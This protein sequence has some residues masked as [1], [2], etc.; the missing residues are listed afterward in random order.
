VSFPSGIFSLFYNSAFFDSFLVASFVCKK[1][2]NSGGA[3]L[4][5]GSLDEGAKELREALG[6]GHH[7][8]VVPVARAQTRT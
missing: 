7:R 6:F 4:G 8:R 3:S 2:P 5:G 1:M